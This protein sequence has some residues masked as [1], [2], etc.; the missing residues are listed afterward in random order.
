MK[1]GSE[2]IADWEKPDMFE[3]GPYGHVAPE[4]LTKCD[5]QRMIHFTGG[6]EEEEKNEHTKWKKVK[7]FSSEENLWFGRRQ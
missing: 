7:S 4:M 1:K 5:E 6:I 3:R 2:G